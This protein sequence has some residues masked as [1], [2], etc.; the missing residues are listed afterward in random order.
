MTNRS[1]W[2]EKNWQKLL[3]GDKQKAP[4][5]YKRYLNKNIKIMNI[6]GIAS[7]TKCTIN[8]IAIVITNYYQIAVVKFF[9]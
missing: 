2:A 8:Y 6:E 9:F 5:R 3:N 7:L 1:C 4:N